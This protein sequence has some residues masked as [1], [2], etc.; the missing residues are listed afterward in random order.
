MLRRVSLRGDNRDRRG[1]VA[2]G[3]GRGV[4]HMHRA[5]PS[6]GGARGGTRTRTAFRPQRP[7]RCVYTS[8]TTR[9]DAVA[10][11]LRAMRVE[12]HNIVHFAGW[13]NAVSL[14]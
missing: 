13:R 5:V 8:F 11:D 4:D 10:S 1:G 9:A 12:P 6:R 2:A 14:V 3:G 7:E